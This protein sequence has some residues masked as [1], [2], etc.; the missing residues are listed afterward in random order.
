[1][2]LW[3]LIYEDAAIG[4]YVVD[5]VFFTSTTCLRPNMNKLVT[6]MLNQILL[7]MHL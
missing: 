1:M 6:D 5:Y 4:T 7:H 3:G 2:Y